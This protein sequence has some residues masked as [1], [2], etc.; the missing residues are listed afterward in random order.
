MA[1]AWPRA[2]KKQPVTQPWEGGI[3]HPG[4]AARGEKQ[5]RDSVGAR[6]P[7]KEEVELSAPLLPLPLLRPGT[8]EQTRRTLS[9]ERNLR[10]KAEWDEGWGGVKFYEIKKKN[11]MKS[12]RIEKMWP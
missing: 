6:E 3:H 10:R 1:E 8:Q 12:Y 2:C 11:S 9:T 5:G 4:Q 7:G